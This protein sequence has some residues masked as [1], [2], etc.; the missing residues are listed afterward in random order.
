VAAG[1]EGDAVG[2][3]S[4][5]EGEGNDFEG[6]DVLGKDGF[7]PERWAEVEKEAAERGEG[8]RVGRLGHVRCFEEKR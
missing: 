7:G 3:S 6:K 4:K 5:A 1:E 8:R 2:R